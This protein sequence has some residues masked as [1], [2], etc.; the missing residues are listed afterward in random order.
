MRFYYLNSIAS[1]S[2]PT[3]EMAAGKERWRAAR[4]DGGWKEEMAAGK[5]RWRQAR[6]D[7]SRQGKTAAGQGEMV[8]MRPAPKDAHLRTLLHTGKPS[9]HV[10]TNPQRATCTNYT[11]HTPRPFLT[12]HHHTGCAPTPPLL[13]VPLTLFH[14]TRRIPM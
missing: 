1:R 13:D 7:S 3:L 9:D 5:E 10:P 14:V 8:A 2:C 12:C 6:R 4:R 11:P